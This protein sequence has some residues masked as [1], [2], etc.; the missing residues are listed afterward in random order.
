MSIADDIRRLLD[1]GALTGAEIAQSLNSLCKY[2]NGK[3]KSEKQARFLLNQLDTYRNP[4]AAHWASRYK[5]EGHYVAVL[6]THKLEA[7]GHRE[8]SKIRYVAYFFLVDEIGVKARAK[9]KY[10]HKKGGIVASSA[11]ETFLRPDTDVDKALDMGQELRD[12]IA[13]KARQMSLN[14]EILKRIEGIPG[15]ADKEILQS[16]YRQLEQGRQLS[17]NQLAVIDSM[18]P[19]KMVPEKKTEVK[20]MWDELI[21]H[22]RHE[23]A[24]VLDAWQLSFGNVID[25]NAHLTRI[26][27]GRYIGT[28]PHTSVRRQTPQR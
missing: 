18:S 23:W 3:W 15:W 4:D 13:R 9:V 26:T 1:E 16:L 12:R 20:R 22:M 5:P 21:T 6:I 27:Q 17:A 14:K 2:S 11:D 28:S 8:Q 7:Y 25:S 19:P 10:D 24:P